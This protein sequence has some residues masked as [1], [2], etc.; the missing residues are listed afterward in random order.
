MEYI[1]REIYRTNENNIIFRIKIITWKH[2]KG[3]GL[4][5]AGSGSR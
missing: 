2:E 4:D 3:F 5:S 1:F